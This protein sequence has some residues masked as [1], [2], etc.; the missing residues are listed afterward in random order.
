M[1]LPSI[2]VQSNDPGL[3]AAESILRRLIVLS[4]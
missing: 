4:L 3:T 1:Q 2:Y